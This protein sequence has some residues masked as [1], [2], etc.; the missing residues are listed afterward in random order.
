VMSADAKHKAQLCSGDEGGGDDDD[1]GDDMSDGAWVGGFGM[2]S[3]AERGEMDARF[4][5]WPRAVWQDG[6]DGLTLNPKPSTGHPTHQTLNSEPY[7]LN[8]EP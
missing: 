5:V 1:G 6:A 3:D 2:L 4:G 7:T 8:P